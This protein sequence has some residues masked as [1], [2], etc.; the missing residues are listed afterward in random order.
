MGK[1]WRGILNRKS[2]EKVSITGMQDVSE[3]FVISSR[4]VKSDQK[5]LI[6]NIDFDSGD[7]MIIRHY[8]PNTFQD[9]DDGNHVSL[10]RDGSR[11]TIDSVADL[12]EIAATSPNVDLFSRGTD[13]VFR[14]ED[15]DGIATKIIFKGMNLLDEDRAAPEP[16]APL[17]DPN[18]TG[19]AG[20]EKDDPEADAGGQP[21][22]G[23]EPMSLPDDDRQTE[24]EPESGAGQDGEGRGPGQDESAPGAEAEQPTAE[25]PDVAEE[26]EPDTM[27]G[28]GP[29]APADGKPDFTATYYVAIDGSDSNTG[30]E[31]SPFR[32]LDHAINAAAP[33]EIIAVREGV[34]HQ[35]VNA[36]KSGTEGNPITIVAY[37]GENAVIDGSGSGVNV[38]LV[39]ISGSHVVFEGFEI[40]DA[41]RSGISVWSANNV[42]LKNNVIHD[43]VKGGIWVGSDRDGG[44]HSNLIEG[45]VVYRTCLENSAKN[46][47]E[48]WARAIGVDV[49]KDTIIKDN[50]VFDN[51]GEGIGVLSSSGIRYIGNTVYDNFSVQMYFDNSQD[52]IVT[53]NRVFHTGD[54][55]FFRDANAGIGILI[56]N[57][58]TQF[59]KASDGYDISGNILAGVGAPRYD[60]SYGWGGG[61]TGSDIDDNTILG[62]D[63]VSDEWIFN[64]A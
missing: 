31:D 46:W 22:T 45:N 58:Y 3:N 48:G 52:V 27:P 21:G 25:I 28:S 41:S 40:R 38:D 47:N 1:N 15:A 18:V 34:Y 29:S 63:Q 6:K 57:E 13:S 10:A 51:Y 16:V 17:P 35:T 12:K 30:S 42:T 37:P 55:E 54:T 20:S 2:P 5:I 14:I 44:S 56:A 9:I 32:T 4:F 23:D 26:P 43:A 53:D 8:S 39:T 61:L 7:R 60:G 49:S 50:I 33:G 19:G 11:A 64:F 24:A 59:Q 36:W 62:F